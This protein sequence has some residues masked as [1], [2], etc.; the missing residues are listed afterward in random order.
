MSAMLS[1]AI[2]HEDVACSLFDMMQSPVPGRSS[3][4]PPN[5]KDCF[6]FPQERKL[7]LGDKN[8]KDQQNSMGYGRGARKQES[9]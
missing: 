1:A 2:T 4:I 6:F 5:L 8:V 7:F 9:A 3:L